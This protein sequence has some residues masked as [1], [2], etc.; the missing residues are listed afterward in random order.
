MYFGIPQI[1]YMNEQ[2]DCLENKQLKPDYKVLNEYP[3]ISAG[4]DQQ[5]RK[6]VQVLLEEL[7]K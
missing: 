1:G 3:V 2:G 6:A 5:L 4:K 7:N